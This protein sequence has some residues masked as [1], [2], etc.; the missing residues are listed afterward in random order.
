MGI[1]DTAMQADAEFMFDADGPTETIQVKEPGDTAW[2]EIQAFVNRRPPEQMSGDGTPMTPLMTVCVRNHATAGIA[3]A[4]FDGN[5]NVRVKLG[6]R[7]NASVE[8]FGLY[9]PPPG[10][11]RAHNAGQFSLDVK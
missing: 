8:E 9:L 6:R 7:K 11:V 5:G 1:F 4:T 3:T 10:S 2:R